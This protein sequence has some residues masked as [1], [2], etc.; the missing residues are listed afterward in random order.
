MEQHKGVSLLILDE[1]VPGRLGGFLRKLLIEFYDIHDFAF[2]N[3][4]SLHLMLVID[5]SVRARQ[6]ECGQAHARHN[7]YD[8][9]SEEF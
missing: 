7:N 3:L 8:S 2:D 1:D 5:G 9:Y 6:G 4:A